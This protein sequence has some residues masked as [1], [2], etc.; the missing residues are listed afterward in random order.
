[1]EQGTLKNGKIVAV[2][3]LI[4]GPSGKVDDQFESEVKLISNVHHRNLVR[5]LGCC[6]KGQERILVYEYMAN[7]S[8]DRFLFGKTHTNL[9][10]ESF[11]ESLFSTYSPLYSICLLKFSKQVKEMIP[12]VGN[13]DMT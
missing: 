12:S 1:M 3:K 11:C 9:L 10:I 6:S 8:L 2:K 13:K 4:L 5:L 7:K